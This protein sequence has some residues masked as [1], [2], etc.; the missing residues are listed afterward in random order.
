MVTTHP[1]IY[2]LCT[3]HN[4]N[5]RK[6]SSVANGL[7]KYRGEHIRLTSHVYQCRTPNRKPH[8]M[9]EGF[10]TDTTNIAYKA[11]TRSA[12]DTLPPTPYATIRIPYETKHK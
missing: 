7:P 9:I 4:N 6:T 10:K 3:T 1:F 11:F 12:Q 8:C 2:F 5:I